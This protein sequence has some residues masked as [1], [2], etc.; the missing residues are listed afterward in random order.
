MSSSSLSTCPTMP[1]I[2]DIF[3]LPVSYSLSS[4]FFS[5]PEQVCFFTQRGAPALHEFISLSLRMCWCAACM[6]VCGLCLRT[7]TCACVS[8]V[9]EQYYCKHIIWWGEWFTLLAGCPA[10]IRNWAANI[11]TVSTLTD[12]VCVRAFLCVYWGPC[13]SPRA[14][15]H[16]MGNRFVEINQR[17]S[18]NK[19]SP[20]PPSSHFKSLGEQLCILQNER[21][22]QSDRV[23]AGKQSR[24]RFYMK[25]S[26]SC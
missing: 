14:V 19:R 22:T 7:R 10:F 1:F 17:C 6:Y 4:L 25:L 24:R 15:C 12:S 2:F 13:F 16:W 9:S 21:W 26:Q 8:R 20:V 18:I 5:V 3:S 11:W 23:Q